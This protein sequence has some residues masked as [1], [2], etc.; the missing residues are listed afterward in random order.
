M[1]PIL[2][3]G[4]VKCLLLAY[5]TSPNSTPAV[6]P[7]SRSPSGI[8]TS[9]LFLF[10]KHIRHP[11]AL[12]SLPEL[13][14]FLQALFL[15]FL[16]VKVLTSSSICLNVTFTI[17]LTLITQFKIVSNLH[18]LYTHPTHPLPLPLLF[19]PL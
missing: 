4:K 19:C 5:I 12:L 11:P 13:F 3:R 6:H 2:Y 17:W 9:L 1:V 18:I 7:I 8:P 15:Q 10:F 16:P 14:L